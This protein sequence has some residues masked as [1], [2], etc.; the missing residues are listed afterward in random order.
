MRLSLLPS[1]WHCCQGGWLHL[2]PVFAG[3]LQ[4]P[5]ANVSPEG[6]SLWFVN[7]LLTNSH[8]FSAGIDRKERYCGE[9]G[10]FL[11]SP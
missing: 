10:K 1:F 6:K 5:S 4:S 8:W 3:D 2:I 11:V 7:G 9:M